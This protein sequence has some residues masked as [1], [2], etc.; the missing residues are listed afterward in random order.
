MSARQTFADLYFFHE[1]MNLKKILS[2]LDDNILLLLGGFLFAFIPLYPKIPLWSPIEQYIVR[3]RVED[4]LLLLT[5]VVWFIQVLRKKVAWRSPMFW[6]V[7]AYAIV[8]AVSNLSAMFITK[9]IPLQPLHIEKSWLNYFRYLEYF[10]FFFVLFSAIRKKRDVWV[11]MAVFA[12][13]VVGI[14]VYG[15][16]QK[17]W[18]WPVYSTMNREFSK[19]IRLVLT[20]HARVQ[21][22]FAGDYD[23][24]AY[25]VIALPVL[26]ALAYKA[27]DWRK[28]L[29]L[30]ISFWMGT[31]LIILSGA[32]SSFIAFLAAIFAV[33][34]LTALQK[35]GWGKKIRFAVSRGLFVTVLFA[36]LFIYFGEDLSERLSQIIDTNQQAHDTFHSLNK[37]R[38][39][40]I[41][42]LLGQQ[43]TSSAPVPSPTLPPNTITTD[44]ALQMGILSPSDERPIPVPP[45]RP[46]DV[47]VDIPN[48]VEVA[49]TSASGAATTVM[50]DKGPRTYSDNALKYGLSM[51][52]RLDTL[53]PHAIQGFLSNPLFG[54]GY[55]T[56]NKDSVDQ[57]TEAESTDNNFLRTLGETG[58]LGFIT[59]YGCVVLVM[60]TAVKGFLQQDRFRKALSIGV[61]CAALGLLLNAIYIDVFASSKVALTFWGLAGIFFGYVFV[62]EREKKL[63]PVAAEVVASTS[64]SSKKTK[65]TSSSRKK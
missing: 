22:T 25:L 20:P 24:A 26:L 52:I 41:A 6:W 34:A 8:G 15:Y 23:M 19:G 32:R 2:W 11:L 60:V 1:F 17:Y 9:M 30:T 56:L 53:W 48:I 5:A 62:V 35:E 42:S 16:G 49:S 7:L 45:P 39:E 59:F 4:F 44:Q 61:F 50:V 13:A 65:K 57:F 33:I 12:F 43:A 18:L 51:A 31:W 46:K 14:T 3:V 47:Y 64:V 36:A 28:H 55:A 37:Q 27:R 40:L 38:K 29:A 10:S 54:K 58:A 21:S 63:Q